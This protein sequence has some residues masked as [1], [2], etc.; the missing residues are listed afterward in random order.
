MGDILHPDIFITNFAQPLTIN[1]LLPRFF[2][3]DV[4]G[5]FFSL[6]L[7]IVFGNTNNKKYLCMTFRCSTS[8]HV[9]HKKQYKSLPRIPTINRKNSTYTTNMEFKK[10]S[11]SCFKTYNMDSKHKYQFTWF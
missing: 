10:F 2:Q 6:K 4:L 7:K 1:Q 8:S 5:K 11:Y 9:D 3:N